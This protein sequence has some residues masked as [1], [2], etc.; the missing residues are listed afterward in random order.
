MVKFFAAAILLSASVLSTCGGALAETPMRLPVDSTPLIF[1]T[2]KGD[3]AMDVE[4]ADD[5][6]K[7]MRGL[8]YRTDLPEDRAMLFVFGETRPVMMWMKN[9]PL[10]L[11][12][13]FLQDNGTIATIREKTEPF[14]ENIVSSGVP[15][16][17]V[18]ELRAGTADR[19]GLKVGEKVRHPAIC[20]ACA[21]K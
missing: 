13:V 3:I 9:T 21:D 2:A 1:S 4:I 19:L 15:V 12:M 14:S 6:G 20:S 18:V 16:A 8:M 5:D 7:R 11:D 10:S 17:Y